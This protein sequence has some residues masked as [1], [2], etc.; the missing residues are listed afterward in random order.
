MF[1]GQFY[2]TLDDKYR[3]TIPS[4][5]REELESVQLY[6]LK[7]FDRNLMLMP[8]A[9]FE[10]VYQRVDRLSLTNQDYRQLKRMILSTTAKMTLDKA[11]R[12]LVPEFLR[13]IAGLTSE[14]VVVG[15]GS[16]IEIWSA[17][18]WEIQTLQM[19]DAD[20]A[21]RFSLLDISPSAVELNPVRGL[22][23]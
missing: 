12:I 13:K 2:H 23:D 16:M 18:L 3:L 11:G 6:L 20:N 21:D 5:F 15:Q 17:A 9:A 7:G 19:Q 8:A 1:L 14:V 4:E 22:T 10:I